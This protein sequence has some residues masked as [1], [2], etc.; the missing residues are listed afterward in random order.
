MVLRYLFIKISSP[1]NNELMNLLSQ[2]SSSY[3][4]F[5]QDTSTLNHL[6]DEI[7]LHSIREPVWN[8]LRHICSS[9]TPMNCTAQFSEIFT[10][11]VFYNLNEAEKS[12]LISDYVS[13]GFCSDCNQ[14]VMVKCEVFVNF[15]TKS[16]FNTAMGSNLHEW[17]NIISA[18]NLPSTL[19]CTNC[20]KQVQCLTTQ[21]NLS[22][23]LSIEFSSD[24]I[25]H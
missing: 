22:S 18:I 14:N 15:I 9:L 8:H 12:K 25:I 23:A 13:L 7:E 3:D 4:T 5:L 19:Q 2:M 21:S 10:Q 1:S 17:Y 6:T 11:N 20:E 16:Y 24:V